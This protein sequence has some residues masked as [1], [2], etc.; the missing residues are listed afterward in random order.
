[1]ISIKALEFRMASVMRA[2]L[3]QAMRGAKA[4]DI[5]TS[6]RRAENRLDAVLYQ[7]LYDLILKTYNEGYTSAG[8]LI[9]RHAPR[10]TLLT[11]ASAPAPLEDPRIAKATQSVIFGLKDSL[12]GH[13]NEIQATMRA[14]FESGES[15]TKLSGR[16]QH[17]FDTN[18]TASTRMARTVTNDV[19]NRAHL[20]RYEDSGVVDG[21]QY[22]AHIDERTS[23]I[24]EMLN[25]TIWALGDKDIQVPP[26][27]FNCRSRLVPWFGK[28]PGKRDFEGQFGSEFV[29]KA[30]DASKTF[31]SKY[32]SP[33]PHTKAS[34][35]YQRSYFPKGDI[36]TITTGLNLAIKE[37]RVRRAAPD[38]IP[39]DRLKGMIRY[40][41]LEPDKSMIVDRFGKSL[42]L[43]KFEERDIIRAVKSLITQADSRLAR[44]ASKRKKIIGDAWK[45][46][47]AIRKGISKMEKD[48]LYY[49]KRMKAD[50]ANAATYQKLME[51]DKRLI[52]DAKIQESQQIMIWDKL[53]DVK[54][55]ATAQALEAEKE[56]YQALLD[57]F[58]FQKR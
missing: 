10:G 47:L 22:S 2:G 48:I 50:P 13:R 26:L 20:D 8:N 57:G 46:V 16:L 33:M 19:Y 7:P 49:Q 15:I 45:E 37:E 9:R 35:T 53:I 24:C 21:V 28:I 34:A 58:N 4:D 56:R 52:M 5:P 41:K 51:Q 36:K 55:S 43:D 17:Y 32:W 39:L 42:M 54:P 6:L 12:K 1:M 44:E 3:R 23:E 38:I 18:R 11:A 31:R 40:R 29:G 27:H 14:G 30:E 25:D